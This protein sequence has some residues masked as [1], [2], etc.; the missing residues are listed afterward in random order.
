MTFKKNIA[1]THASNSDDHRPRSAAIFR[2]AA[3]LVAPG[4]PA[5]S[6]RHGSNRVN[7]L[8]PDEAGK[9]GPDVDMPRSPW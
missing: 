4:L 3:A 8:R 6:A 5:G 2:T 1:L 7:H 9:P